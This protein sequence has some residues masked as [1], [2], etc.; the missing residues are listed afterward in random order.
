M[1]RLMTLIGEPGILEI[2][3]AT[4]RLIFSKTL[5]P[6]TTSTMISL[7]ATESGLYILS[8]SIDDKQRIVQRL[9]IVK[10]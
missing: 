7:G 6:E 10:P 5:Q 1:K 9:S 2:H 3:D 8:V 4:G